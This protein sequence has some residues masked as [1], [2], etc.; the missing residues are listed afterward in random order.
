M[1]RSEKIMIA[2]LGASAGLMYAVDIGLMKYFTDILGVSATLYAE[3]MSIMAVVTIF[4]NIFSGILTDK[5]NHYT[6]LIKMTIPLI[7]ILATSLLFIQGTWSNNI[8]FI[9]FLS[10]M[11]MYDFVKIVFFMNYMA[12]ILNAATKTKDR[13]EIAS[14]RNYF[15][16]IPAGVN[17]L[18]PI[19][20]FTGGYSK[21]V[22][23]CVFIFFIITG[24]VVSLIVM[25][26]F[27][28]DLV[29]G[30]QKEERIGFKDM[31]MTVK[32][33]AKSRSFSL[34][35][36]MM[37]IVN[38]VAAVYYTMYMYYM[39]N[40]MHSSGIFAALPDI[41]GAV[42][43]VIVFGSGVIIVGKIGS[44]DS[45]RIG[46]LVTIFCYFGLIFAKSYWIVLFLYAL[47]MVG[48]AFFWIIQVPLLGTIVDLDELETGKRK[49]G[50]ILALNSLVMAVGVNLMN[51]LFSFLL[52]VIN[53]NGELAVQTPQTVIGLRLVIGLIPVFFLLISIIVLSFMPINRAKEA[54]VEKLILEKHSSKDVVA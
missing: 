16:F 52:E 25:H 6:K 50:T 40:I 9:V 2:I 1:K 28:D 14:Y 45:L 46:L 13:T 49:S 37:I 17:S 43:Q 7:A 44:R 12:Y 20:L 21:N 27:R 4:N 48:F 53:Y 5:L 36:I 51:A 23:V 47:S 22:I 30:N 38:G 19:L 41:L 3:V 15:G 32:L 34:Y 18:V 39:E 24:F 33:V 29:I 42:V 31:F 11:I 35:F 8:I 54:E 10:I 26:A